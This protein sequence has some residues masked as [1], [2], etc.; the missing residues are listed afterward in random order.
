MRAALAELGGET[1]YLG[2]VSIGSVVDAAETN[3]FR[4]AL[5]IFRSEFGPQETERFLQQGSGWWVPD[6]GS[7]DRPALRQL[8]DQPGRELQRALY[9]VYSQP[10]PDLP[11][12]ARIPRRLADGTRV[13]LRNP[14]DPAG[15]DCPTIVRLGYPE[16]RGNIAFVSESMNCG[17]LCG[18]SATLA[19]RREE[20][21]WRYVARSIYSVA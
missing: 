19:F 16:V 3:R 15:A 10:A 20:G 2:P 1:G 12:R 14:D 4:A 6:P 8:A 21:K 5:R 9:A 17:P 11:V 7:S 18:S 13:T